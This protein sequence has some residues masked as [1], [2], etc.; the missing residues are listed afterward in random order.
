MELLLVNTVE[1]RLLCRRILLLAG[2]LTLALSA[3]LVVLP[4]VLE[5]RGDRNGRGHR[6]DRA[7]CGLGLPEWKGHPFRSHGWL[8]DHAHRAP[9]E[10]HLTPIAPGTLADP[11]LCSLI[12]SHFENIST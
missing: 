11:A 8:N 1:S 6:G 9:R 3:D 4:D 10:R 2:C 12:I 5:L 7:V